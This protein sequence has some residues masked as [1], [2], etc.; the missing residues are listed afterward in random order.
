MINTLKRMQHGNFIASWRRYLSSFPGQV[1]I[2]PAEKDGGRV[3]K[4][5]KKS[6]SQSKKVTTR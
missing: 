1:G 4:Q 3:L 5:W 2:S 6:L